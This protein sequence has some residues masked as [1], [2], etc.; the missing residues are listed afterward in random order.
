MFQ[1]SDHHHHFIVCATLCSRRLQDSDQQNRE[2]VAISGKKEESIQRLQHRVEELLQEVASLT[3]QMETSK[4]ESRRHV[5]QIKDR[6]AG[7]VHYDRFRLCMCVCVCVCVCVV[8]GQWQ[9]FVH[10]YKK[11][12]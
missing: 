10:V 5:E 9:K 3:A 8:L 2:L 6:A 11:D 4:G 12:M 7:K 1:F